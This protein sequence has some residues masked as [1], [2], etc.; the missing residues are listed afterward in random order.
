M[1]CPDIEIK[2][3]RGNVDTRL[4]KLETEEYDAFVQM[5]R[6]IFKIGRKSEGIQDNCETV[7]LMNDKKYIIVNARGGNYS[8]SEIASFEMAVN[9]INNVIGGVYGM[10][11][12]GEVIIEGHTADRENAEKIIGADLEKGKEVAKFIP[13]S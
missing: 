2:W 6:V 1:L 7:S 5:N 10:E 9:Y 11:K 3:I 13:T 4:A 8:T 12:I